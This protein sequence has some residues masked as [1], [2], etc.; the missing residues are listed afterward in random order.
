LPLSSVKGQT[1]SNQEKCKAKFNGEIR[2]F[3]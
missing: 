1:K 3:I 2:S